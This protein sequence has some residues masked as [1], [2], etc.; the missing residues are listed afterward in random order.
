MEA[1]V[2]RLADNAQFVNLIN[3]IND[4]FGTNSDLLD[5]VEEDIEEPVATDGDAG[6][7]NGLDDMTLENAYLQTFDDAYKYKVK[8]CIDGFTFSFASPEGYYVNFASDNVSTIQYGIE[9]APSLDGALEEA[10]LDI[11]SIDSYEVQ[12][13]Q[14]NQMATVDGKDVLYNVQTYR[15][16]SMDITDVTAVVDVEDGVYIYIQASIYKDY[17]S[18]TI[19]EVL[20]A[21]S[22][23]YYEK[24]N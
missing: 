24:M 14:L 12:D 13:T 21:L 19:E 7:E 1:W 20:Q 3:M 22:S 15:A 18:F 2:E 23:Q 11:S 4:L 10:Y 17:D 9:T 6:Y 5:Q 16:F 8:G